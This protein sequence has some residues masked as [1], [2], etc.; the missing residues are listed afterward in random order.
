MSTNTIAQLCQI[1]TCLLLI[2]ITWSF[3]RIRTNLKKDRE[4]EFSN[5]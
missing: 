1:G 5:E 3:D 4:N 2:Y